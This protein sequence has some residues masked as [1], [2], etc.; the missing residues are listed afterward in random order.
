M[1]L[2]PKECAD[3][4]LAFSLFLGLFF[5]GVR[6]EINRY[7]FV[8]FFP[9]NLL[10]QKLPRILGSSLQWQENSQFQ[11]AVGITEAEAGLWFRNAS[12]EAHNNECEL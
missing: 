3:P 4:Q 5:L 2:I 1:C 7:I 10:V 11:Q 8:Y 12:A 6:D 9:S